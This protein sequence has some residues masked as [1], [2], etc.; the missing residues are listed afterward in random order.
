MGGNLKYAIA[1][2]FLKLVD[3]NFTFIKIV[4]RTSGQMVQED[5]VADNSKAKL[6]VLDRS[7]NKVHG[8]PID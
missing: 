6:E 3:L 7:A 4:E 8:L 1:I 2:H 5:L